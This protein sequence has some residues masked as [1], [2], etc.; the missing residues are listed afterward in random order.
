[1]NGAGEGKPHV[2]FVRRDEYFDRSEL[3]CTSERDYEDNAER[4]IFLSKVAVEWM[5][6]RQVYPDVV[7]CHDW[8]AALVP[9]LLRVDEQTHGQ[10]IATK[11]LFTIHN[12]QYQGIFW[13]LD[14]PITNLPWQ[15]FTPDGLEFYGQ[16]N[17]MKAGILFADLLTTVSRRYAREIQT[18]ECGCGLEEPIRGRAEQLRGILNGVNYDEWNPETDATIARKFSTDDLSGKAE[19]RRDLMRT[20][21][22]NGDTSTPLIGVI[23]RLTE[24]KG[25][26][27]MPEAVDGL[28]KRNARL[29]ILGNGLAKYEKYWKD[30]AKRHPGQIAVHIGQ[31]ASLAHKI[32]AGADF[33]LMPSHSEPCGL[34]EMYGLKYGTIPLVRST[35]GFKDTLTDFDPTA[36]QGNAFTFDDP[37]AAALTAR[38]DEALRVFGDAGLWQRLRRNA[39]AC[40][41]GWNH[42][43]KEYLELYEKG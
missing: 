31:D 36:G 25:F 7:H 33:L 10:R 4:F 42:A 8:Q 28:L 12:L 35:G 40:D 17:L 32:V 41:F 23:S 19:C 14:F 15:F 18:A 5:R 21:A 9:L 16:M 30:A 26:D 2:V 3:Y 38:F 37:S 20:M 13:S 39:M 1:M 29:A 43:A 27:M 6:V 11:T 34:Y 22:L 24:Q